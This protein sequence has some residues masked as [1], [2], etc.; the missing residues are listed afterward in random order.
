MNEPIRRPIRRFGN[1]I[2]PIPQTNQSRVELVISSSDSENDDDIVEINPA[3]PSTAFCT[4][5]RNV[6]MTHHVITIDSDESDG[7]VESSNVDP[8][9]TH[10]PCSSKRIDY[11]SENDDSPVTDSEIVTG[12]LQLMGRNQKRTLKRIHPA[13]PSGIQS[14]SSSS[15]RFTRTIKMTDQSARRVSSGPIKKRKRRHSN[16]KIEKVF[17]PEPK[18]QENA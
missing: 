10:N 7:V 16:L 4:R 3:I 12:G 6:K 11:V 13:H 15:P 17:C 2:R 14:A 5:T 1:S 9:M 18:E 8:S